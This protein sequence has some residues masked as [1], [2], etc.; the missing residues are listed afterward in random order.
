MQRTLARIVD[1]V[2]LA[3]NATKADADHYWRMRKDS[4]ASVRQAPVPLATARRLPALIDSQSTAAVFG[5]IS[6][7]LALCDLGCRVSLIETDAGREFGANFHARDEGAG[8]LSTVIIDRSNVEGRRRYEQTYGDLSTP[9]TLVIIG[10]KSKR[11]VM[12]FVLTTAP[13][14]STIVMAG[15]GGNR[16]REFREELR[17]A[18]VQ[19][20]IDFGPS[21]DG[22][23]RKTSALIATV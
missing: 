7:A 9:P 22:R 11:A 23:V 12:K 18:G 1:R 19:F 3:F 14:G 4:R 13:A 8:L 15:G 20:S 6:A 21:A 5:S 10:G 2:Y 16:Y 17:S